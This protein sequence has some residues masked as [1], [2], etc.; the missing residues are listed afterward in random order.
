MILRFPGV[1]ISRDLP[2]HSI[3]DRLA[4]V[5]LLLLLLLAAVSASG[6]RAARY[7]YL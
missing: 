1:R 3:T 5:L 2:R 6:M 4:P 7:D